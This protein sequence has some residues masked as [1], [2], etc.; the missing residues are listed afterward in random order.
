MTG[1]VSKKKLQKRDG[2][3]WSLQAVNRATVVRPFAM[4]TPTVVDRSMPGGKA[5]VTLTL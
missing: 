4:T 5:L 3:P 1:Q 2:T